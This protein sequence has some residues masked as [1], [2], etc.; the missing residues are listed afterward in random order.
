[1]ERGRTKD[2]KEEKKK[3]RKTEDKI[4]RGKKSGRKRERESEGLRERL[5]AWLFEY[6]SRMCGNMN[7][8]GKDAGSYGRRRWHLVTQNVR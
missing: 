4:E 5:L 8:E 7:V 2:G 3:E 1:M 6:V